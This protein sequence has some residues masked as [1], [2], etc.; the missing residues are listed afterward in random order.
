[1]RTEDIAI[2]I[3]AIAGGYASVL[4]PELRA[5]SRA[6][7]LGLVDKLGLERKPVTTEKVEAGRYQSEALIRGSISVHLD[8]AFR[9]SLDPGELLATVTR[10]VCRVAWHPDLPSFPIGVALALPASQLPRARAELFA[11]EA[12]TQQGSSLMVLFALATNPARLGAGALLIRHLLNDCGQTSPHARLIAF[13]PLT[14]LRARVIRMVSDDTAWEE[15]SAGAADPELLLAQVQ[16]ALDQ[17]EAS[18][19]L[20]EP[21]RGWLGEQARQFAQSRD[22]VVGRFHRAQGASLIGVAHGADPRDSDGMWARGLFDY[23]S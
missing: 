1:M 23:V 20:P 12:A 10:G 4:E 18:S 14:G 9:S 13:S 21:L 15:A 5:S 2:A 19:P 11:D 6:Q 7:L 16:T 17:N 22:Y 8:L 3:A